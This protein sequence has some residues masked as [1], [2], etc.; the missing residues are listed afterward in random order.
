[1]NV[2]FAAWLMARRGKRPVDVMFHEVR[3]GRDPG[4]PLRHRVLDAVNGWMA[5]MVARSAQRIFVSIPAWEQLLRPMISKSAKVQWL[6]VPTNIPTDV[7]PDAVAA[8]RAGLCIGDGDVLLG[9]FGTYGP[10]IAPMLAQMLP[11]LVEGQ[12][13]T[14][15]LLG[16]DGEKFRQE[17]IE[18]NPGIAS[19]VRATGILPPEDIAAGITACDVMIQPYPDGISAR[20]SSV[21]ASIALG[22][23]VVSS[24]GA[25]S[26][27]GESRAPPRLRRRPSRR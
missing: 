21:M 18:R 4:Q 27:S 26:E 12:N 8:L 10:L 22:R 16:R 14:A 20:R 2:A 23:P 24:E 11:R 17:L 7:S 25:L 1:M 5:T 19:Q 15:L 6:G 9:H 13:R 3:Y